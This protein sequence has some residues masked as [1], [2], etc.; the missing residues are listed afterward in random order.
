[1]GSQR[2]NFTQVS[3]VLFL[4]FHNENFCFVGCWS[5]DYWLLHRLHKLNIRTR[6]RYRCPY[7]DHTS[8]DHRRPN[9]NTSSS[10]WSWCCWTTWCCSS[11]CGLG[12]ASRGSGG[13]SSS[14]SSR[15]PKK[16]RSSGKHRSGRDV[17]EEEADEIDFVFKA[18]SEMDVTDCAKRYLCEIS[19]TPL[20]QLAA[21]DLNT[22][23]LFQAPFNSARS[24]KKSFDEA[25]MLGAKTR[26]VLSCQTRYKTCDIQGAGLA[27]I[28]NS[29][30]LVLTNNL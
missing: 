11:W 17:G 24:F 28:L 23:A 21:K 15:R 5:F 10:T 3:C 18:I 29:N 26:N 27:E 4:N 19:A 1:M 13:G 30:K 2:W 6:Y 14:S 20:N 8:T 22:L 9:S 12:L 25:A 7:F 16:Q